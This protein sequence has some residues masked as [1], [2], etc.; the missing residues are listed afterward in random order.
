M[1]GHG[2]LSASQLLSV[3]SQRNGGGLGTK[4]GCVAAKTAVNGLVLTAEPVTVQ[5]QNPD[6]PFMDYLV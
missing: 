4:A 1:A 5:E 2:P 3:L 6:S